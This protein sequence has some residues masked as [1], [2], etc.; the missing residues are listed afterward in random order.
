M[1]TQ[2]SSQIMLP[3]QAAAPDGP[4]D[5]APMYVIHH[6]FR[7]DLRDFVAAAAATPT[8]DHRTWRLLA[9]R[10]QFFA[11]VLHKHHTAED[12]EIWPVLL[13]RVTAAHDAQALATMQAMEDE[14]AEID[15]LLAACAEGFTELAGA[16]R[17]PEKQGAHAAAADT[18]AALEIRLVAARERLDRHLAH[19]ER[20]AISLIQRY[21]TPADWHTVDVKIR[22]V[23]SQRDALRVLPWVLYELPVASRDRLLTMPTGAAVLLAAWRLLWRP[24]FARRQRRTFRYAN[25][26]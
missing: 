6:A 13:E 15:P 18:R 1:T 19:E 7:R 17:A 10:W 3:G 26:G 9:A 2:T 21:L 12:T 4:I 8:T 5:M 14:H 25:C 22:R 24:L 20:D 11:T 23:Y 16:N